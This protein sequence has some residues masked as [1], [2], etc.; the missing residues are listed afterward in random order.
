M[1]EEP[2]EPSQCGCPNSIRRLTDT[3]PSRALM[4]VAVIFGTP[5]G[6]FGRA[7]IFDSYVKAMHD[8]GVGGWVSGGSQLQSK[9]DATHNEQR[10]LKVLE[11]C[12]DINT[13]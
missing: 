6:P 12:R 9:H 2:D 7:L 4:V 10:V 1:C 8:L 11:Q 3:I 13:T 5:S